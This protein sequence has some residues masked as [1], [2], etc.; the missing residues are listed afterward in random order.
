LFKLTLLGLP[1]LVLLATYVSYDPFRVLYAYSDLYASAEVGLDRDFV[2][3]ETYLRNRDRQRY[4]SFVF[5]S[6]RSWAF[7]ASDWSHWIDSRAVFHFDASSE[8]LFGIVGKLKLLDASGAHIR[9]ALFVVETPMLRTVNDRAEHLY[10]KHPS[11]SGGSRESFQT[12]FLKAYFSPSFF[13]PYLYRKATGKS[14]A[15]F[16]SPFQLHPIEQDPVTNDLRMTRI[17]REI[18]A[19]PDDYYRKQVEL[20]RQPDAAVVTISDPVIGPA[21]LRLLEEMRAILT[22][23][24]TSFHIVVSP[25]FDQC[26]IHPDDLA[27]L[28]RLLGNERV[29]DYSGVNRFTADIHNYY[30]ASHYRI[31]VGQK[32]MEEAYQRR[33]PQGRD[34]ALPMKSTTTSGQRASP[35]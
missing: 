27:T 15:W 10:V 1:A 5:G 32:I 20:V 24:D 6:S 25:L 13:V 33:H 26:K 34:S 4:D 14:A 19:D 31:C 18:N 11:V 3:T 23:H 7:P 9:N 30:E 17:E 29:F 28:R 12:V 21:Q 2:S 22:K 35:E 16:K 8:T